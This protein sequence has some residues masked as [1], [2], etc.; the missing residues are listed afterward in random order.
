MSCDV[1]IIPVLDVMNGV[2]VRAV[3]GRRAEY[4]PVV[5][6]LT[7]S[8]APADVLKAL[9]EVT[10]SDV[11]YV[12]DLDA[13]VT[14][15]GPSPAVLNLVESTDVTQWIDFGIRSESELERIPVRPNLV[16]I[17]GTET[18]TSF[19]VVAG[20][21]KRFGHVVGS[22][23]LRDGKPLGIGVGRVV[24]DIAAEFHVR[25]V[26]DLIVLDL[27]SV[28]TASSGTVEMWCRDIAWFFDDEFNIYPGG[29]VRN[30]DD[31]QRFGHAGAK[32]VLVASALHDGTLP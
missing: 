23:D 15:R 31:L 17:L 12:A 9:I 18:M 29:G 28:G 7:K 16:P 3:G 14:G 10:G 5:S 24:T 1:K 32:G 4:R 27:A 19:D 22:F 13:I 26:R 2:V 30:R 21:V 6:K 20:A 8:T 25:D 11:A